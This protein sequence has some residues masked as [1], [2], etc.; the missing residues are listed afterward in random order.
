MT[1]KSNK[2]CSALLILCYDIE[3]KIVLKKNV[4]RTSCNPNL[5]IAVKVKPHNVITLAQSRTDYHNSMIVL[6]NTY[7]N[8]LLF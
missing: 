3:H 7:A 6:A 1:N 8:S 2:Y 4:D 5:M